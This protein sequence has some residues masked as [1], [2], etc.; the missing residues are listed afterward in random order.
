MDTLD[1]QKPSHEDWINWAQIAIDQLSLCVHVYSRPPFSDV[2]IPEKVRQDKNDAV[3]NLLHRLHGLIDDAD[4][5][6]D[7]LADVAHHDEQVIDGLVILMQ[8]ALD[9]LPVISLDMQKM[10]KSHWKENFTGKAAAAIF[11]GIDGDEAHGIGTGHPEHGRL[12]LILDSMLE[13]ERIGDARA[14]RSPLHRHR[15]TSLPQVA[16]TAPG[17]S[18]RRWTDRPA[19]MRGSAGAMD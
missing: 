16:D 7:S 15:T 5:P 3:V 18:H 2:F 13:R 17:S 12:P 8:E 10:L 9:K 14:P 1:T 4:T 19:T 11:R 6:S